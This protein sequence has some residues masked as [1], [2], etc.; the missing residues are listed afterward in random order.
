MSTDT[1]TTIRDAITTG[2][3]NAALAAAFEQALNQL[4]TLCQ[5]F[6]DVYLDVRDDEYV[7]H[8]VQA[9]NVPGFWSWNN[10]GFEFEV[11]GLISYAASHGVAP[12]A[13]ANLVEQYNDAAYKEDQEGGEDAG[14]ADGF[15]R[16]FGRIFVRKAGEFRN[17]TGK[18]EI[19]FL[20]GIN[21]AGPGEAGGKE[22]L[23]I[24]E[25]K[26]LAEVTPE[27]VADFGRRAAAAFE[28]TRKPC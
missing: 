15:Y 10:G 20:A 25:V 7:A 23:L 21:D 3:V 8:R 6:D 11:R 17:E 2:E 22:H 26:P 14:W 9:E 24:D 12:E 19:I 1:E 16:Y 4:S 18:D 27:V 13:L 28:E 5:T